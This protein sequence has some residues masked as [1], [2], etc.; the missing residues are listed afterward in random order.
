[1]TPPELDQENEKHTFPGLEGK[2]VLLTGIGQT[3]D[4]KLWG[5]GAATA[6]VLARS[7]AKIFGCDLNI[8]AARH[9]QKRLQAEG[10][11][12][13]VMSVDVTNNE[14]VKEFVDACIVKYGRIDVLVSNVGRSEPGGPAEMEERVWD[15]QTDVNL[16]SVYLCCHHVLPHMEAQGSGVVVNVASV[17]GIRYI[18]KPQVAYSATKAAVIQFTKAT[19]VLYANKGIR[20]NV[21][22]PG[23]MHTPLLGMLAE[24]Y[25]GGDLEGFIAKRNRQV[26]MGLMGTSFDVANTAGFL[27]S[28]A[29]RYIT[30]QKIVVD[31]GFTSST[32]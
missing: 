7:G 26:P 15:A 25:A 13:T 9:T 1:M 12:V 16:K 11:E 24:K 28:I 6:R 27:A 20:M 32:G 31:G 29:S 4:Q 14:Q 8:E 23:L 18:G 10:A 21:V 30:G 3:G 5:N 22:V 19:A 2:V 17:A